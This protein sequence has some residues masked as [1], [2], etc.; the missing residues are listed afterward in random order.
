MDALLHN[1][2]QLN[3]Q[4]HLQILPLIT[5]GLLRFLSIV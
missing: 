1:D 2:T 5:Q 4:Y 3:W